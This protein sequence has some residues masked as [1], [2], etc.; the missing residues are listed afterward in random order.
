MILGITKESEMRL[1]FAIF[2]WLRSYH[3]GE[4][5]YFRFFSKKMCKLKGQTAT[6][7]STFYLG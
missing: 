6:A 4:M 3:A 7:K 1:V 5:I 2:S